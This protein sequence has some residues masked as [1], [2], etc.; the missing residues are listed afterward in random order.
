MQSTLVSEQGSTQH[1]SQP[2]DIDKSED[3]RSGER[4]RSLS[5]RP[6]KTT[7]V[8]QGWL[9]KHTRNPKR[10]HMQKWQRRYFMLTQEDKVQLTLRCSSE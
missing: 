3:E 10:F 7:V 2:S 6:G 5:L 8:K 4:E 1:I 9:T